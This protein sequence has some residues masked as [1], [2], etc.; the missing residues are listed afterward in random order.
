[1][2]PTTISTRA[3]QWRHALY[4]R[5]QTAPEPVRDSLANLRSVMPTVYFNVPRGFDMLI[6]ALRGT[7][8]CAA[9]LAK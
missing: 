9:A 5:R 4:R 6:A 1:L 3:A 7:T 8:S 2:A